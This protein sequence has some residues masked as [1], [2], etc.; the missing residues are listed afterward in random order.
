MKLLFIS[1]DGSLVKEWKIECMIDL[2]GYEQ[3]VEI[4]RDDGFFDIRHPDNEGGY[5]G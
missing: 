2:P 3:M 5:D 4:L 1:D